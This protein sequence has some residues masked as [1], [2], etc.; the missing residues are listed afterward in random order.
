MDASHSRQARIEGD[1]FALPFRKAPLAHL[2]FFP[3]QRRAVVHLAVRSGLEHQL[4]RCH[5]ECTVRHGERIVEGNVLSRRV[6]H[7]DRRRIFALPHRRLRTRRQYGERLF[8]RHLSRRDLILPVGERRAVVHLRITADLQ[9]ERPFGDLQRARLFFDPVIVR[10]VLAVVVNDDI[11]SIFRRSDACDAARHFDLGILSLGDASRRD[12]I[13]PIGQRRTVVHLVLALRCDRQGTFGD[14]QRAEQ[15]GQVVVGRHVRH[16]VRCV[17]DRGKRVLNA[18]HIGQTRVESHFFALPVCKAALAHF[19]F[20]QRERRA[21]VH[22]T[23]RSGLQHQLARRHFQ[24]P[25][26]NGD[27]IVGGDVFFFRVEDGDGHLVLHLADLRDRGAERGADR[28]PLRQ[29]PA[30]HGKTLAGERRA[31]VCPCGRPRRD[32]DLARSDAQGARLVFDLVMSADV[33]APF[34]HDH[35]GEIVGTF[36]HFRLRA[37]NGDH[38]RVPFAQFAADQLP[39]LFPV[40]LTVVDKF[41]GE[42]RIYELCLSRVDGAACD[43]RKKDGKEG[44]DADDDRADDIDDF[45]FSRHR[46]L[47]LQ[48]RQL[49]FSGIE[50]QAAHR[51][52]ALRH[53]FLAEQFVQKAAES[54]R[55]VP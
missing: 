9:R 34:V 10:D 18:P 35:D 49:P 44:H 20:F 24:K 1:A 32:R 47:L 33:C 6:R 37:R 46:L 26:R 38:G 19:V 21:V 11:Q 12:L 3:H 13:V 14:L 7:G 45:C 36:A 25:V 27:G 43:Q 51:R 29:L 2:V 23:F 40:R 28:V 31:V 55:M 16:A 22:L 8:G 39:A 41:V 17:N 15:A 42:G 50:L 53:V 52:F 5:F 54:V 4:A 48:V 30:R